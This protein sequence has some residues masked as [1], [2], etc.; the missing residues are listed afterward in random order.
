MAL[1]AALIC[2]HHTGCLS[3]DPV[4]EVPAPITGEDSSAKKEDTKVLVVFG[5]GWCKHCQV[6]KSDLGAMNTKRFAIDM[7]DVDEEPELKRKNNIRSLPTSIILFNGKEES[8]KVGYE[9]AEFSKWL[10]DNRSKR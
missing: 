1:L 7:V 8:R 4:T 3:S 6:L 2:L 5:A 9:K 10:D